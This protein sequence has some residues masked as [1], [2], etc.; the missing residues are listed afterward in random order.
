VY[1]RPLVVAVIERPVVVVL[2]D[3]AVP[4]P[5]GAKRGLASRVWDPLFR[6]VTKQERMG[7]TLAE[8]RCRRASV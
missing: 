5:Y 4:S 7:T 3:A 8:N 2:M 1:D 6:V